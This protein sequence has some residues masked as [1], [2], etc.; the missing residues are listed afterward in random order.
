MTRAENPVYIVK[1]KVDLKLKVSGAPA[2]S[3]LVQPRQSE[4]GGDSE[5]LL[6]S[7]ESSDVG[8]QSQSP[9]LC[10]S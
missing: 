10:L 1:S 3:R 4:R 9:G 8:S 2:L 7:S 6:T 5:D